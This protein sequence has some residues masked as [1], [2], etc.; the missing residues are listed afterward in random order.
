MTAFFSKKTIRVDKTFG[1]ILTNARK[2]RGISLE[3][4]EFDTKV[5]LKYL[6]ALEQ[7]DFA[8]MP[9][10]VYNIGF[11][12]RYCE[13][14]CIDSKKHIKKYTEEKKVFLQINKKSFFTNSQR[15]LINPG[16]P[17]KYRSKLKFVLTPQIFVTTLVVIFVVGILGYIWF[18]VKSFAAA[19]EL[20]VN[21]PEEQIAVS[22]DNIK[23]TG[24]TDPAADL[25]IN[26]QAV[27]IDTEGNFSQEVKLSK[28]LNT[29]EI[30]AENK[31]NK[32]TIRNIKVLAVNEG[33]GEAKGE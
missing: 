31:A 18:Q 21:N 2:K 29:I 12:S 14:L 5:R 30:K 3:K 4:A 8:N 22:Q 33:N 6:L 1:K 24:S 19:P 25:S 16:D 28:G 27:N 15:E 9:P 20:A 10:D 23:I 13:Y 17:E 26:N 32:T 7:D 11:L